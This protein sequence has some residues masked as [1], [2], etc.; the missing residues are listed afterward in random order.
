MLKYLLK[1]NFKRCILSIF[2]LQI[3]IL[4]YEVQWQIV[5]FSN[6]NLRNALNNSIRS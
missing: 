3:V 4:K 5:A 6:Y 1:F 2:A